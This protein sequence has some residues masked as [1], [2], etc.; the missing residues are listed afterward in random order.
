MK[1]RLVLGALILLIMLA[2]IT[3]P[4]SAYD[5]EDYKEDFFETVPDGFF[6]GGED[7]LSKI[8]IDSLFSELFTALSAGLGE[9]FPLFAMLLGL[10]FLMALTESASPFDTPALSPQVTAGVGAVCSLFIF[11]RIVPIITSTE[12]S[13]E[14]LS[15][16][17][18]GLVPIMSGI[19][20]SGGNA[21]SSASQALNMNI[22]LSIVSLALS[23]LLMPLCFALFALAL[24]GGFDSGGISSLA[25][26][27][28]GL[29]MWLLGI[30][31][32]V[33]IAAV[34]MQSVI[35]GA[36]DSAYLR[37]AKYAASGMIPI[38]GSTVSSA[39]ATLAGGLSYVK[40]TVGA[41]SVFIIAV[42]ALSPL[43]KLLLSRL[44]F[45]LSISFLEFVSAPSAAR[46]LSAFRAALDALTALYASVALIYI[47]E[48][49]VFLKSGVDVFG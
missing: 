2:L 22:T 31:E 47:T 20:L 4:S 6:E 13:L 26:S 11:G 21:A 28:K 25:K 29:F 14:E 9:A 10:S 34:S 46:L 8:G 38:V 30:G 5:G 49:L 24:I 12:A 42:M 7:E 39:L 27:I 3:V 18:S 19:L 44:A 23:K 15:L 32:A 16:F 33:I 1:K 41:A 43:L 35:S 40:S 37:A 45:S 36:Q 17:F 48:T